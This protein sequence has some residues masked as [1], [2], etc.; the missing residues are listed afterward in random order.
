MISS[1]APFLMGKPLTF[2]WVP[3]ISTVVLFVFQLQVPL[4]WPSKS[5]GTA[6]VANWGLR[7]HATKE[8]EQQ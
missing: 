4:Q 3:D 1:V 2:T 6:E 7:E 5:F 8:T